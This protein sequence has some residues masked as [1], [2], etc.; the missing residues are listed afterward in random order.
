LFGIA[1]ALVHGVAWWIWLV[2]GSLIW[3]RIFVIGFP[4]F[5]LQV[6]LSP[7]FGGRSDTTPGGRF[8]K[9]LGIRERGFRVIKRAAKGGVSHPT[10]DRWI[11]PYGV[12]SSFWPSLGN[13]LWQIFLLLPFYGALALLAHNNGLVEFSAFSHAQRALQSV[14]DTP[15]VEAVNQESDVNCVGTSAIDLTNR[16]QRYRTTRDVNVRRG[17]GTVHET[18]DRLDGGQIVTAL[19]RSPSGEWAL[20]SIDGEVRCFVSTDYLIPLH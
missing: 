15:S 18:I 3:L 1:S 10:D 12:E 6:A 19:G 9:A 4:I 7:F 5:L 20:V 11:D 8:Q 2:I 17:P 13:S 14:I 16:G